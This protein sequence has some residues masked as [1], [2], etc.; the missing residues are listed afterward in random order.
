VIWWALCSL[1]VGSLSCRTGLEPWSSEETW[2]R[3]CG[4]ARS[5]RKTV[6]SN[7]EVRVVA[8]VEGVPWGVNAGG[9]SQFE[10]CGGKPGNKNEN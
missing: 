3:Q 7:Y 10:A 9:G 1:D 6:L 5:F 2:C 4:K 8:Q